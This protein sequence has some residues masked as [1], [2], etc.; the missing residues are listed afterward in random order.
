MLTIKKI[1]NQAA[2]ADD[3]TTGGG[4][5]GQHPATGTGGEDNNSMPRGLLSSA[6]NSTAETNEDSPD[7]QTSNNAP[8]G[9]QDKS[10]GFLTLT[11]DQAKHVP[12]QFIKDDGLNLDALLK[13]YKD[14]RTELKAA[15]TN[16]KAPGKPEDYS[17]E[18]PE[19]PDGKS[20]SIQDDDKSM[21]AAKEAA[22]KYGISQ[23]Q[24]QGFVSDYLTAIAPLLPEPMPDEA[25]EKA[26]LGNNADAIIN[27]VLNWGQQLHD[28]GILSD[29]E[30]RE[31][32]FIGSTAEGISALQKL[33]THYTGEKTIPTG[34]TTV[35]EGL[36]SKEELYAA[37]AS[38]RYQTDAAFR[39]KTDKQFD[40]VFGKGSSGTSPQGIGV[41]TSRK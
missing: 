8:A 13:S 23:D 40:Q 27:G 25:T 30:H 4:I 39:A 36:P 18:V 41:K 5:S 1:L 31:L 6:A 34:S 20:I 12:E 11:D 9:E 19:L 15:K 17:F 28:T 2:A 32:F 24:F 3:G 29:A 14:T 10:N 7:Q 37:A 38:E 16:K 21:A 22:H 26:K 35:G 33:R